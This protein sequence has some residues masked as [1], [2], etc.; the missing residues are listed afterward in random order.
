LHETL[1]A[2]KLPER[3]RMKTRIEIVGDFEDLKSIV[4]KLKA[5]ARGPGV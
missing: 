5:L 4:T 3:H 2:V 1:D